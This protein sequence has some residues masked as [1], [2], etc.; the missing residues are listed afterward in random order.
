M[1]KENVT[2]IILLWKET[3]LLLPLLS[4]I[5]EDN[6]DINIL[7][8]DNESSDKSWQY[9]NS[10]NDKRLTIIKS[11]T[12]LGYTGGINSAVEYAFKN[13]KDFK[14]FFII[15]PDAKCTPNLIGNLLTLLKSNN[16]IACVSPKIL[17]LDNDKHVTYSGG[18]INLKKGIVT[19]I[20]MTDEYY[21]EPSYEMDAYH[22]CAVLFDALKFKSVGM[23]NEDIFIY[24]DEAD[25]SIKLKQNNFKILYAPSLLVYHDESYTMRKISFLK[26]YYMTRN[27]FMVFDKT[28]SVNNKIHFLLKEFILHLKNRRIKNAF[29][30]FKGYYHFLKGEKGSY[31]NI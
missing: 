21:P 4:T 17:S 26:T 13:F 3:E 30:H 11:E 9:F 28:M 27:R 6:I 15:N 10:L 2:I 5:Q 8:L 22:G 1:E 20:V 19:H 23:L 29:Y 12:N 7:V 25:L 16:K 18:R 14:Y 24:F 31:Y